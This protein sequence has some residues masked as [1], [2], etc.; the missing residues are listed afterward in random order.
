MVIEARVTVGL[1]LYHAT[2]VA[3]S[4]HQGREE[5]RDGTRSQNRIQREHEQL[6]RISSAQARDF[7][8]YYS[9]T[10]SRPLWRGVLPSCRAFFRPDPLE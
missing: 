2:F 7:H 9:P 5:I 10:A 1:T 8:L 3:Q 4:S 6:C